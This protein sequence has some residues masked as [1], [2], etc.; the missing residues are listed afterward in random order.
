[1]PPERPSPFDEEINRRVVPALKVHPIVLGQD[2]GDLFPA[3]VA[4]MDFRAPP[5]VTRA[6]QARLD[7]G[8]F[9]YETIADGLMPALT[10]WLEARHNWT[11]DPSHILRAPNVLNPLAIAASLFSD[12]GDGVIIQPPVFFDFFDILNENDRKIIPNPLIL[13]DGRYE[14]DFDGLERVAANPATKMLF[15]CNPH[16]PMG[17]VWTRA[18]LIRLGDICQRHDILVISDEM[19]GDLALPGHKYTPFASLGAE[20]AGRSITCLSPAKTFNIAACCSGFTVIADDTMRAAFQAEN[21]RLT[22]NK[23]NAF[24]NVAMMAA[25][26]QGAPWLDDLIT[27]ISGNLDLVRERLSALPQIDLIEPQG[28]FLVWLDFRKL[29]LSPEALTQFLRGNAG[30]AVSRGL[31]FG[32]EGAGFARLNIACTRARLKQALKQMTDAITAFPT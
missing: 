15:L 19:H 30:W 16:N 11:V 8:V 29:D 4:D 7:H 17:R 2:G 9:G 3:S 10:D 23:N 26:Q 24:T 6:M 13:R 22:V 27:Y 14:M 21:S 20:F 32:P 12:P 18:E 5:C 25:Y 28:G 31:A 1:M